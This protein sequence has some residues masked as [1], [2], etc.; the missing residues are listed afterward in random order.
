MGQPQR[1]DNAA[2]GTRHWKQ[3]SQLKRQNRRRS[4]KKQNKRE[5]RMYA[6]TRVSCRQIKAKGYREV[7]GQGE[8]LA[9]PPGCSTTFRN[10]GMRDTN[11]R[12]NQ[13]NKNLFPL[14]A[15]GLAYGAAAVTNAAQHEE[16]YFL[17]TQSLPR[18]AAIAVVP[19]RP[20]FTINYLA[21]TMETPLLFCSSKYRKKVAHCY[22]RYAVTLLSSN[23]WHKMT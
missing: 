2:L 18:K 10:R 19:K 16:L 6:G 17:R 4:T 21:A 1:R 11:Q 22:S 13:I 20:I 23:S 3:Q 7:R 14:R 12:L 15:C 9:L 5:A 8:G